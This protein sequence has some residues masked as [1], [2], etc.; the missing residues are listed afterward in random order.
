MWRAPRNCVPDGPVGLEEHVRL[1]SVART[2]RA[3]V[4]EGR[5]GFYQ[6]EFGQAL[7]EMGH[8]IFTA[9]DLDQSLAQWD[10]P[11]RLRVWGHDLWTM[12]PPSQGYLTLASSWIAEH[13]GLGTTDP[14]DPLWA[15]LV[16]EASRAA[17]HDRPA[18]LYDGA[19]GRALLDERRLARAAAR[20]DPDVA[21]PSDVTPGADRLRL[22]DADRL[23]LGDAGTV[24]G[25]TPASR[26]WATGIRPTSALSTP[27]V[28]GSR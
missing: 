19:D 22:G 18:V 20:I 9:E 28:S 1:P 12:P 25:A 13:V 16:V 26:A 14:A 8:G 2:L 21:A 3:I 15:H 23:R 24:P 27:T 4:R 6:G 17:G 5:Q 11:L 10:Q 7:I